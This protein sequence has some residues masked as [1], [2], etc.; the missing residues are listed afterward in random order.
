M[1]CE[2]ISFRATVVNGKMSKL[3]KNL[4]EISDTCYYP[5]MKKLEPMGFLEGTRMNFS[6]KMTKL[7]KEKGWSQGD[8]SKKVGVHIAHLSR[9]EN[10]KSQPSSELLWKMA[11]AFGVSADYLL[12][13]D[14]GEIGPVSVKDKAL[15]KRVEMIETLDDKDKETILNVIDSM[16]TKKKMLD[17]L[18]Q[19]E[20]AHG[21]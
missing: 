16:L 6:E 1:I 20:P 2:V 17:L 8:L 15:A 3:S 5:D 14:A 21:T 13:D 10:G 11:Q 4:E 9:L 18:V 12:D 19:R 7:R